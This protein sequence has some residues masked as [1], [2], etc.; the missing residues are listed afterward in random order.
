MN[1]RALAVPVLASVLTLAGAGCHDAPGKPVAGSEAVR[2][3]QLLEFEPLYAQNCASC[4]GQHGKNG[5]ALSLANPIYLAV[6][7]VA[8]IQRVTAEGVSGTMM[9]PFAKTKGGMLTDQQVA[10][11]AQ[12]MVKEWGQPVLPVGQALPAYAS[13]SAGN[14]EKGQKAYAAFCARCHGADGTGAVV[15]NLHVGS[16]VDP[17]YLSLISDQ[18]LRSII[19]AG[20]AEQGMPDWRS[21]AVGKSAR[22]L[23]DE[24]I[25]DIVAWIATH[26]IATPGQPYPQKP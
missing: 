17:A 14:A 24:E 18:G 22:P 3:D 10:A 2:P 13:S 11:L 4:H 8:N 9:P 5:A 7:G 20:Q 16:F 25:A 6:A 26:R 19:I 1:F 15:G 23:S 21:D 12:G